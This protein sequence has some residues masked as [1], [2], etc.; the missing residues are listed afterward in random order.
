[1]TESIPKYA[2]DELIEAINTGQFELYYQPQYDFFQK[3]YTA[4]EA[5]IR[6]NHPISGVVEPIEFMLLAEQYD[7]A[8]LFGSWVLN[9]ACRQNKIWQNLGLPPI[10]V[11]VNIVGQQLNE[12]YFSELVQEIL[13]CSELSPDCLELEIAENVILDDAAT[14]AGIYQLKKLGIQISLDDF[15]SGYANL[16]H[17]TKVPIDRVK[18]DKA[19]IEDLINNLQH[20]ARL[21]EIILLAIKLNLRV[22]VEG[23]ENERQKQFLL[24]EKCHE[25]QGFYF[26]YPLLAE[27]V[28]V[29]LRR[30]K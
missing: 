15:G 22:L 27:E 18:I 2:K 21:R 12:R 3:T 29:L 13:I 25:A 28:T 26:S 14:I 1:M 7:L 30:K 11:A 16:E 5:L 8:I 4:V 6:W 10:R 19:Y 9:E 23:V 17:L 24:D 20:Q